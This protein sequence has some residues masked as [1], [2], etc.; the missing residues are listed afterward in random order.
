[1]TMI[2]QRTIAP[3]FKSQSFHPHHVKGSASA[4]IQFSGSEVK[5]GCVSKNNPKRPN[6]HL[7]QY[8]TGPLPSI[9][10]RNARE[11]N[12]VKQVNNGFDI[13]RQYIPNKI[14]EVENGGRATSKKLS[15]VDTL[16]LAVKYIQ[17]MKEMLDESNSRVPNSQEETREECARSSSMSST[18][19][20]YSA[21][22][23]PSFENHHPLYSTYASTPI[24]SYSE[25]HQMTVCSEPSVSPA[26]S[27]HSDLSCHPQTVYQ[28]QSVPFS[29]VEETYPKAYT[30]AQFAD[31]DSGSFEE[32]GILDDILQWQLQN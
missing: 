18:S 17:R 10:R 16:K 22:P 32:E 5:S 30:E 29:A 6:N 12:R 31:E 23:A 21:S 9:E 24:S 1:M 14:I 20:Y 28:M 2:A 27:Y 25:N 11:R 19:S 13:L 3:A 7:S 4:G 15:K 26:P 8:N